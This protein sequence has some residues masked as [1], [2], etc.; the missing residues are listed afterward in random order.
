[1]D[2]RW[3]TRQDDVD[4]RPSRPGLS[5]D[6]GAAGDEIRRPIIRQ[7]RPPCADADAAVEP[8]PSLPDGFERFFREN[9]RTLL[10]QARYAGAGMHDADDAVAATMADLYANWDRVDEPLAWARR[11]V[12]RYFVKNKTRSLDRVRARQVQNNTGVPV[13]G[14]DANLTS[15]EDWQWIKQ[16]LLDLLTPE[17][18][19]VMSL[20]VDGFTPSEIADMIGSTPAAV[21]QRLSLA[22]RPLARAWRQH[23]AAESDTGSPGKEP[24]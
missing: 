18:R 13:G 22:R 14:D 8:R 16:L 12:V 2:D 6:A 3:L 4:R 17:Q 15:W 5:A 19:E 20:V 1:V 9:Y 7:R 10:K 23:Q 11:A 21:R 24:R